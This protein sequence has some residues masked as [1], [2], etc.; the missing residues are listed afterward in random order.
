MMNEGWQ[1]STR[2]PAPQRSTAAEFA[3]HWPG[4]PVTPPPRA[5]WDRR[6]PPTIDL[7]GCEKVQ[8]PRLRRCFAM[9]PTGPSADEAPPWSR[10]LHPD[11]G[12]RGPTPENWVA[13]PLGFRRLPPLQ[14]SPA[15]HGCYCPNSHGPDDD[16]TAGEPAVRDWLAPRAAGRRRRVGTPGWT[17][18]NASAPNRLRPVRHSHWGRAPAERENASAPKPTQPSWPP[19]DRFRPGAPSPPVELS[20]PFAAPVGPPATVGFRRAEHCAAPGDWDHPRSV[21]SAPENQQPVTPDSHPPAVPDPGSVPPRHP[22]CRAARQR[23]PRH[24]VRFAK[25]SSVLGRSNDSVATA[26][27]VSARLRPPKSHGPAG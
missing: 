21:V 17:P 24:R 13:V 4:H 3:A 25:Y 5:G 12:G 9:R 20:A 7:D 15:L 23:A 22:P 14:R 19:A 2:L 27:P 1:R 11:L 26:P 10:A 6:P 16:V 8:P 18:P